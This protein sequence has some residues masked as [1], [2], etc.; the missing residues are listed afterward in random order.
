MNC[1]GFYWVRIVGRPWTIIYWDHG[2]QWLTFVGNDQQY[3]VHEFEIAECRGPLDPPIL[4]PD[5][6]R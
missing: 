2:D 5:P 6:S 4:E 3:R 1:D